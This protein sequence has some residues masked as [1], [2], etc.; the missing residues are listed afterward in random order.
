MA[1]LKRLACPV[2]KGF[3]DGEG[4]PRLKDSDQVLHGQQ[5]AAVAVMELA[6][7]GGFAHAAGGLD[8]EDAS[9]GQRLE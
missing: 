3:L 7:Q 2:V 4:M 9:Q 1:A 5:D 6:E 8:D